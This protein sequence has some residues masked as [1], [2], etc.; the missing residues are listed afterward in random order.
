MECIDNEPAQDDKL[1]LGEV[2]DFHHTPHQ[3][4]AI[5]CQRKNS[6][7]EK[8]IDEQLQRKYRCSE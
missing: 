6:A 8:A 4:H 2:D 7:D 5:G 1:P 3:R